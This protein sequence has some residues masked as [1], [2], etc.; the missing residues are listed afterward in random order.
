MCLTIPKKV[1]QINDG[2]ITVELLDG[3][4]QVVK[5]IVEL[6]VGDFCVT[7]QNVAVEKMDT[8][9]VDAVFEIMGQERLI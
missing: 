1:V 7:Q 6:E 8:E 3:T 2:T 5:S 9:T 4:R